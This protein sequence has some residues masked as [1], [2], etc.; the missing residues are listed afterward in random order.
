[1]RDSKSPQISRTFLGI[2][3]DLRNIV[4]RMVYPSDWQFFQY[5]LQAT[6]Y[7]SERT[8]YNWYIFYPHAQQPF[9]FYGNI[10]VFVPVFAFFYFGSV[11]RRNVNI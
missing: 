5:L 9:Q 8:N 11:I 4:V 1:M 2:L 3:T 7:R 10:Q 6:G